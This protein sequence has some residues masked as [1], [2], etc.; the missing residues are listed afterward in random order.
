MILLS[1]K[2]IITFFIFLLLVVKAQTPSKSID[3]DF[4]T[5]TGPAP[6]ILWQWM[7]GCVTR[8]GITYDLESFRKVGIRNVQQ[9]LI[10]GT[11]ANITDTSVTILGNKWNTLMHFSLEECKRLEM[12]FGTH[13]CPG[14]SASGA[15]GLD[16]SESMQ[17]LIW[18]KTTVSG[19]TSKQSIINAAKVD[20]KWNYYR[21]ICIIAIPKNCRIVSK[22]SILVLF[23]GLDNNNKLKENL[24]L[25]E[26]EVLRFGHTTT[27]H[28]NG[29]APVSGQGLEVDK[30][31]RKSVKK[32]WELY[33]QKLIDL[34]GEHAGKAFKR[35]E[36]DSYEAGNQDWTTEMAKE[37]KSRRNYELY[38]WLVAI[39]GYTIDS[40]EVTKR[41]KNDWQGTI[42]EVIADNYFKYL[43]ELIHQ[44]PGLEFVLEPYGT[45]SK[46]F[47]DTA[48][49]G[50]GDILMAEFWMKPTQWGW[51]TLLPVSSNAHVNGRK[52]VSA[53][54]FTG[55]PQYAFQTDLANLK[56]TGDKA[57]CEGINLFALHAAAHQPW[58][59]VKPGMTMGWWGTQFGPSQ[60]WWEHGA[61]EWVQYIKRC[62][63]LLQ[64]GLFVGDLCYLQLYQQKKTTIP[65]GYKADICNE[66]EL[67]NRFAV[68]ENKLVLPDGMS[69]RLLILPNNPKISSAL[70]QKIEAL[71]NEGAIVVGNGFAGSQGLSNYQN[72]NSEVLAIGE[73]L[74]GNY[75]IKS[76]KQIGK[77][78]VYCNYKPEEV[79]SEEKIEK[80]VEVLNN[81]KDIAW[82]HR[83]DSNRHYFFISNQSNETKLFSLKFRVTGMQ[84]EVWNATTGQIN[85]AEHWE[86]IGNQ[87][88][89]KL[90]LN[91]FGSCFVVFRHKTLKQKSDVNPKSKPPK[92]DSISLNNNWEVQFPE[93]LG[94]PAMAQFDT[95]VPWTDCDEFGI[96]HFSGTAK[97][98][99]TFALK[100]NH[101]KSNKRIV[102]ELGTVKNVAE[103]TVNNRKVSVLWH[104]PFV[105]DITDYCTKAVNKLEIEVTN[106]WPNR[107]IGDKWEPDDCVWG[108]IREFKYVNPIP[109]IGRNLQI[110]PDWVVNNTE[111]PNKNRIS[112]CTMDFFEKETALLTS[113][114]IGPAQIKIVS[115]NK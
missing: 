79:L 93:K 110:V 86:I 68:K 77:G 58:P 81:E 37:F 10:G 11:E 92:T 20:P 38:P 3:N 53:E 99:K 62:Q 2:I 63:L 101:L 98:L 35:F 15:P 55:Q 12:D 96:K 18:A 5:G 84:P 52:I 88:I 59:H 32:F 8:D 19:K 67:I 45:G 69:Y 113:G 80:D 89:V 13:N 100:K 7:N 33:P 39:A 42:S 108:E 27:G 106:L 56:A 21:D 87:T 34:A 109:K 112:F 65:D 103:I 9:F 97:Y 1:K 95:L 17:K 102:L 41:F 22:D 23:N 75:E 24:P 107:I 54:S 85:K 14:W 28:I 70:A 94:A 83:N 36:L 47:D 46:N 72:T 73:R 64:K 49:R 40:E 26:W 51:E 71:V 104:P 111:R 30:L 57:F 44:T 50:I 16:V 114:L 48:I 90:K 29:T 115:T 78:K 43:E 76:V 74:F 60:T 25:G 4:F 61:A 31:S 82:I 91:E 105:I 6:Y 66:D